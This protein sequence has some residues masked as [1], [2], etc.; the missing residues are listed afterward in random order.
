MLCVDF[1]DSNRCWCSG[2][3]GEDDGAFCLLQD[4]HSFSVSH[5]LQAV[6]VHSDDLISTFQSA[7]FYCCPLQGMGIMALAHGQHEEDEL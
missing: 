7:V 1:G 2:E 4:I 3:H 5:T 6:A